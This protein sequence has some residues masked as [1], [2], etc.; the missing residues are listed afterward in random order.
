MESIEEE[1]PRLIKPIRTDYKVI[2][3]RLRNAIYNPSKNY[4][5]ENDKTEI[6]YGNPYNSPYFY[7]LDEGDDEN[8]DL[9]GD[10]NRFKNNIR[11]I[12][13]G[14]EIKIIKTEYGIDDK[15]KKNFK[16]HLVQEKFMNDIKNR[17]KNE[18]LKKE[19]KCECGGT[20]KYANK[21]RHLQNK[22]HKDYERT[23]IVW[24]KPNNE[25]PYN[26]KEKIVCI[27]G[28]KYTSSNKA[29]HDKTTKHIEFMKKNDES[30][31][32]D[33]DEKEIDETEET[34]DDDRFLIED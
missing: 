27:C 8:Q 32:K 7:W 28:G 12:Q 1:Q 22:I 4:D 18:K 31:D 33:T 3:Y 34:E 20:Y 24:V 30:K 10:P 19:I 26:P 13:L 23:G 25:E 14:Y 21:Q 5:D 11:F 29:T 6:Q 2:L 15:H 17:S 16:L 9:K